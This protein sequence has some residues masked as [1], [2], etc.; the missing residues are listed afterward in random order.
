[1]DL[2]KDNDIDIS[3]LFSHKDEAIV[4]VLQGLATGASP[5][6]LGMLLL[7]YITKKRTIIY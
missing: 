4:A 5:K 7:S 2:I 1:L 3:T 6:L